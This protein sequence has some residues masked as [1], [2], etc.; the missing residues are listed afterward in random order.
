MSEFTENMQGEELQQETTMPERERVEGE[1]GAEQIQVL[2]GLEHIRKRPGMYIGTVPISRSPSTATAAVP[3]KTTAEV[4]PLGF[5]RRKGCPRWK[6]YSRRSTP[7]VNSAAT[8]GIR[9]PRV[10]TA[11]ASRR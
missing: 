11:S 8:R 9:F 1:Y 7:A 2:D 6:S 3:F 10:C 4:S 5:T